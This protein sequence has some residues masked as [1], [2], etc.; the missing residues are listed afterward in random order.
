M[1]LRY[2]VSIALFL[3]SGLFFVRVISIDHGDFSSYCPVMSLLT[4][5]M[6]QVFGVLS[7]VMFSRVYE[8]EP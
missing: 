4:M 8:D 7:L 6:F 2:S 1:V 5:V 3:V